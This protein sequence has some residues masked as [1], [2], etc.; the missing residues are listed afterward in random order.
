[1]CKWG[2]DVLV[3]VRID[4]ALAYDGKARWDIKGIDACIAD[5][6]M[7]LNQAGVYTSSACC[8]H[9]A[10]LGYIWLSDGRALII[11]PAATPEKIDKITEIK[12]I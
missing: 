12:S 10:S 3:N 7:V 1:M 5:L 2:N 8:G 4:P 11:L 6:V 9:G